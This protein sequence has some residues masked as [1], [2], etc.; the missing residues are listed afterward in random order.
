MKEHPILFSGPMVNAILQGKKTQTRRVLSY[1]PEPE[2]TIYGPELFSPTI[3]DEYGIEEPGPEIYGI[4]GEDWS[5]R[6]PYGM[7]GDK[8][9]VRE[10][11]WL[12]TGDIGAGTVHYRATEP[13]FFGIWRPSIHMPRWACR[14][15]LENLKMWVERVQDISEENAIAEGVQNVDEFKKIWD[16]IN[17]SR[18][19]GWRVNPWVWVIEFKKV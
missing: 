4:Y 7:P 6:S 12:N 2:E 16:S 18:G 11:H 15:N 1:Q 5:L 14:L 9:W 8:L 10:T 13:E 3:V 19:F 17:L